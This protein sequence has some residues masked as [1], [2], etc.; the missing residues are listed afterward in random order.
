[1]SYVCENCGEKI[2][3]EEYVN[4]GFDAFCKTCLKLNKKERL[5]RAKEMFEKRNIKEAK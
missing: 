2:T 4:Q 3:R 1:M 5:K